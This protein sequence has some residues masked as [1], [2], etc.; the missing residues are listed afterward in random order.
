M[1]QDATLQ[2]LAKILLDVCGNRETFL[3]RVSAAG[4]PGF[5]M[6]L[7]YLIYRAALGPPPISRCI[8]LGVRFASSA[9]R[10]SHKPIRE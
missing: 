8:R 6:T 7:H 3:I 9:R 5:Q 10:R 2:I 1:G 4:Q